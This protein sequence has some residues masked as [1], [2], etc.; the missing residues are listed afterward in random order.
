MYIIEEHR[1]SLIYGKPKQSAIE[2]ILKA[3]NKLYEIV[4]KELGDEI[5]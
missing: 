3:F 1:N 4:K 2:A 5:A